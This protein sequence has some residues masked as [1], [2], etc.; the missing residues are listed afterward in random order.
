MNK[1]NHEKEFFISMVKEIP[2]YIAFVIIFGTSFL[3]AMACIGYIAYL[4]L[5][6]FGLK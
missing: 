6:P 2:Y 5:R 1:P 4:L 3:L